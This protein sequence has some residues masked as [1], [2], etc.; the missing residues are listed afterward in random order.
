MRT[1]K[2]IKY[3]LKEIVTD[4]AVCIF[5]VPLFIGLYIY[6]KFNNNNKHESYLS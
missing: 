2:Y 4:I 1:W 3:R 6:S 5:F